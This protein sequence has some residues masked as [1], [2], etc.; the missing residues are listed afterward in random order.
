MMSFHH[1]CL[2]EESSRS[3]MVKK[4]LIAR[5]IYLELGSMSGS[6]DS[7]QLKS[8]CAS[9][10]ANGLIVGIEC[11]GYKSNDLV[12]GR[13]GCECCICKNNTLAVGKPGFKCCGYK[14]ND[15][16]TGRQGCECCI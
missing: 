6:N 16:V 13:P 9:A 7:R 1:A 2:T 4:T 10:R 11:R 3:L 5:V 15:L 12:T 14:S 8:E